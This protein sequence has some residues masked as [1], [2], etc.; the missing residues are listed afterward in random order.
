M[1]IVKL[2]VLTKKQYEDIQED[3][4][5]FLS[6]ANE[7]LEQIKRGHKFDKKE[8]KQIAK[9]IETFWKTCKWLED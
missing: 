9:E 7:I 6:Y 2:V 3:G 1:R 8:Q 4:R 5:E